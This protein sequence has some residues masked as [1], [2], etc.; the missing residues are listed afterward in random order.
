[1]SFRAHGD[2]RLHWALRPSGKSLSTEDSACILTYDIEKVCRQYDANM[3]AT[4]C[5]LAPALE[6]CWISACSN[7]SLSP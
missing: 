5:A 3:F 1:M 2:V 7:V 6:G 4:T